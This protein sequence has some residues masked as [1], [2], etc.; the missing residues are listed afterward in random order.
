[1]TRVNVI[2]N[3]T[4]VKK[5]RRALLPFRRSHNGSQRTGSVKGKW[6]EQVYEQL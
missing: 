3:T 5:K 4:T 2:T 6:T 1:M